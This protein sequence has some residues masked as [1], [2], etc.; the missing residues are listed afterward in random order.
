MTPRADR[1]LI[2]TRQLGQTFAPLLLAVGCL[3]GPAG[4]CGCFAAVVLSDS[5]GY[6]ELIFSLA[7]FP[8]CLAP[9]HGSQRSPY[10]TTCEQD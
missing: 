10:P 6:R 8:I 5:L 2:V 7:S 9:P 1:T 4:F 3:L